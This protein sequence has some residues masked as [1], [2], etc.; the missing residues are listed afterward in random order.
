MAFVSAKLFVDS[1]EMTNNIVAY[2][3]LLYSV[4]SSNFSFHVS[5]VVIFNFLQILIHTIYVK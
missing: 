3:N 5:D 4:F 1:E 2:I